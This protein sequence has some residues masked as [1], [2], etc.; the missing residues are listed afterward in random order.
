MLEIFIKAI[1]EIKEDT[2]KGFGKDNGG[3][4]IAPLF[5][6]M[7]VRHGAHPSSSNKSKRAG[8]SKSQRVST[9]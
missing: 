7:L 9:G 5:C 8:F 6:R 2:K 3:V 4:L 1:L